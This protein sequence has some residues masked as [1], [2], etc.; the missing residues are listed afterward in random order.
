MNI[1]TQ[2]KERDIVFDALKFFAIF[3]VLWGHAI[4]HLSTREYF[5]EPVYRIIYSFH[6]PLFMTIVGYFSSSIVK[7]NPYPFLLK[8]SRQL[9]LP[10]CTFGLF[11]LFLG[12]YRWG[13]V[14][15]GVRMWMYSFWFLKCAFSCCILYY[16][17]RKIIQNP[18]IL[19]LATLII[20]QFCFI[21]QIN[22]MYPCFVFGLILHD[23][24]NYIRRHA[25]TFSIISGI[26]FLLMLIPW[27]AD[28]WTVESE[29]IRIGIQI[30]TAYYYYNT[31]RIVIGLVGTLFFISFFT[32]LFSKA[33]ASPTLR[34]VCQYGQETLGIYLIQ[35]FLLELILPRFLSLDT[36]GFIMY[37]F[38]LTPLIS[39][40]IL[41][42][43]LI[44]IRIIKK[45]GILSFLLLGKSL[46]NK[47]KVIL[48]VNTENQ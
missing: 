39:L 41:I 13:G 36:Q 37:N 14:T 23:N 45:S 10:A 29:K 21:Y 27:N 4:Q 31:Y 12:I 33:G 8:K 28:F 26:V 20:S 44:I 43:C 22:R 25:S 3:L 17:G 32:V 6:M 46:K 47:P 40:V 19:I 48:P 34:K 42:G 11:F 5:D 24:I 30:N 38:L 18:V 7:L 35:T 16:F 15:P 1:Q 2:I 9:L